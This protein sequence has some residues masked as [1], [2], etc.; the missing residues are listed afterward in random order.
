MTFKPYAYDL[1]IIATA[2]ITKLYA[3][4]TGLSFAVPI[5]KIVY[6]LVMLIT[7]FTTLYRFV[8]EV[9]TEQKQKRRLK[10]REERRKRIINLKPTEKP[11]EN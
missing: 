10:A 8:K 3:S 7:G 6:V 1:T 5:D 11:N 2:N 4:I 9:R